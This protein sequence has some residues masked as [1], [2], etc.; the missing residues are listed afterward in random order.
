M[1]S[2]YSDLTKLRDAKATAKASGCFVVEKKQHDKYGL[3]LP[4]YYLLYREGEMKNFF[5]GKRSTVAGL[6]Q[7]VNKA[8]KA[9]LKETS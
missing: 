1:V 8:C 3:P 4:S 6:V 9:S 2:Q 5:V 7:L